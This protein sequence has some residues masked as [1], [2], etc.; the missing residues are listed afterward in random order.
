MNGMLHKW[1][2]GSGAMQASKWAKI[3]FRAAHEPKSLLTGP[4]GTSAQNA[5]AA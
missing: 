4:V 5:P 2:L 1:N 3:Q